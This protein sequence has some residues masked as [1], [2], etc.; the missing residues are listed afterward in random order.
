MFRYALL[1]VSDTTPLI[2]FSISFLFFLIAAFS[3]IK[4]LSSGFGLRA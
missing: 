4:V 1:G 3:S 2:S